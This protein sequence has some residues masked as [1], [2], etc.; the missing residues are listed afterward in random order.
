[1]EKN[2]KIKVINLQSDLTKAIRLINKFISINNLNIK[3][4]LLLDYKIPEFG[5]FFPDN[6]NEIVINPAQF[7]DTS[8]EDPH[9][10]NYTCDFSFQAVAC[11][12]FVHLISDRYK[13]WEKYRKAFSDKLILNE[14][15]E[16][17]VHEEIAEA[18][19]LYFLNPFMLKLIS[20]ERFDFFHNMF[21][22]PTPITKQNFI[23]KYKKWPKEIRELC[24]KEWKIKVSGQEITFLK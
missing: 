9:S 2:P 17:D 20:K 18:G 3:Y 22:S 11:H 24:L 7:Q 16:K 19:R 13:I 14:N 15:S 5:I 12:E 23:V 21:E 8:K 10:K 6:K 1:M 4:T